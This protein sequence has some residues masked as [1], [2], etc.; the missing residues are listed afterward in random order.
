MKTKGILVILLVAMC[1]VVFWPQVVQGKLVTIEIEAVVDDVSDPHNLLGGTVEVSDTITGW[2]TYDTSTADSNPLENY[3]AY[4][5]YSPP[6]AI[7]LAV[8][9]LDFTTNPNDVNYR[10]AISNGYQSRDTYSLRSINNLPLPNGTLVEDIYWLLEDSTEAA[11]STDALSTS[12]P[13]L[14]DWQFNRL[15]ISGPSRGESFSILAHVTAAIPEPLTLLLLG[16]GTMF[17]RKR[18]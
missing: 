6:C 14:D 11:V 15:L 4:W 7:S 16:L 5:Y 17:S 1:G 18:K 3:A 8:G 10:I 9:G 2:Y 12:P 13:V